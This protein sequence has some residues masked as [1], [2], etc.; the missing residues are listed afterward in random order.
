[1]ILFIITALLIP[2]NIAATFDSEPSLVKKTIEIENKNINNYHESINSPI[3]NNPITSNHGTEIHSINDVHKQYSNLI[4]TTGNTDGTTTT[5]FQLKPSFYYDSNGEKQYID[6]T[7]EMNIN[8]NLIKKDSYVSKD[9]NAYE[10]RSIENNLKL[11]FQDNFGQNDNDNLLKFTNE[12]FNFPI[13]WKPLGISIESKSPTYNDYFNYDYN[14]KNYF[15]SSKAN[16]IQNVIEYPNIVP[17]FNDRYIVQT[18]EL[19]H[20]LQI[21][22]DLD[23]NLEILGDRSMISDIRDSND[24]I[25]HNYMLD[26]FGQLILPGN[27]LPSLGNDIQMNSF[28]TDENVNFVTPDGEVIYTFTSSFVYEKNN[29]SNLKKCT[30]LFIPTGNISNIY[31]NN[32]DGND[33]IKDHKGEKVDSICAQ[34][35]DNAYDVDQMIDDEKPGLS[36]WQRILFVLRT[37]VEWLLSKDRVYPVI[38]DPNIQLPRDNVKGF[39][40]YLVKGNETL[41]ELSGLNFGRNRE[42]KISM[43]GPSLFSRKNLYYRS[44]LKFSGLD[45]ISSHAQILEANLIL[46]SKTLNED[47]LAISV[48]KLFDNWVEGRGTEIEPK[49]SGASW[50]TSGYNV[51]LGGNYDGY[52][53]DAVTVDVTTNTYYI[54]DVTDI[55]KDWVKDHRTNHGFLLTGTD[56]E[57]IIKVFHS[58]EAVLPDVRPKLTVKYNTPPQ[59]TGL[60]EIVISE[61]SPPISIKLAPTTKDELEAYESGEKEFLFVDQ[62]IV[63]ASHEDRLDF[64]IWNGTYKIINGE[65]VGLYFV[66]PGIDGKYSSK[67]ITV[68]LRTDNS[69]YITPGGAEIEGEDIIPIR[70]KD[71][72]IENKDRL[73]IPIIFRVQASNDPPEI[74]SV[75]TR[76]IYDNTVELEA[77]EGKA[78]D[79]Q[80]EVIDPDNT[81]YYESRIEN[82]SHGAAADIEFRWEEE[83]TSKFTIWETYDKDDNP[84]AFITFNPDNDLVGLFYINITVYDNYW[85]KP[86]SYSP[87]KKIERSNH[88]VMIIFVIENTNN[89]PSKLRFVKPTVDEFNAENIIT[90]EGRCKD[91]DLSIPD[92][93]ENL[94]YSWSSDLDGPLGAGPEI[95]TKL[96]KGKHL[97]TLTVED[98]EKVR[99]QVTKNITVRN[100]ARI[101]AFN[102]SHSYTDDE[103]DVLGYYYSFSDAGEKEYYIMKQGIYPEYDIFIDIVELTSVR[104]KNDLLVNLTFRDN[105]RL[106][107]ESKSYRYKFS[108]YLIKPGHEEVVMNLNNMEY[109]SRL[110]DQLYA[111]DRSLYYGVLGLEDGIVSGNGQ[112]LRIRTHLGDLE[113]GEGMNENLKGDFDLFATVKVELKQHP[114]D[115]FEHLICYDSI[116]LG[117][118]PAPQ[119]HQTK[120]VVEKEEDGVKV[121]INLVLGVLAICIVIV[122]LIVLYI[123]QKKI[124]EEVTKETMIDTTKM[125]MPMHSFGPMGI[126][127]MGGMGG[128]GMSGPGTMQSMSPQ[129]Q[130]PMFPMLPPAGL[131]MTGISPIQTDDGKKKKKKKLFKK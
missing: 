73:V 57:D 42:L 60:N 59:H 46:Q 37:D 75:D 123:R 99:R 34:D 98:S 69:L 94:L 44:I 115:S 72:F 111:P 92:S 68:E 20:E 117:A 128:M 125:Q 52:K 10:F 33:Y 9:E 100:P 2:P 118:K 116:G 31:N 49:G 27:L 80:I 64:E 110:Y 51:W 126:G 47:R 14:V 4:K 101:S 67:N 22:F 24:N 122:V 96:T 39:D 83:K 21:N 23:S 65:I 130:Q 77:T 63:T 35:T 119:P 19:K 84:T 89:P 81:E 127:G 25:K 7:I 105:L 38:I 103:D 6:P 53:Q 87:L 36:N 43:A 79:Y 58:S 129:M 124:E 29:P 12:N 78:R 95:K 15:D 88:T 66:P 82:T 1:L 120:K 121:N 56:Y 104:V 5:E 131:G 55:V 11:Y 97:I 93:T 71:R 108:I 62:D 54:W 70:V 30:S 90:F 18:N 74:L 85:Y 107:L 113:Y 76:P 40:T 13:T 114:A 41:P 26:Y 28:E 16:V 45:I 3:L 86:Y 61:D 8:S 102:C 91:P 17:G 109:E 48:Y 50:N 32:N 112:I 106:N